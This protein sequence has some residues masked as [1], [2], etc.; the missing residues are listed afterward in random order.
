MSKKHR[1]KIDFE[2]TLINNAT[3]P[4]QWSFHNETFVDELQGQDLNAAH[5]ILHY[6]PFSAISRIFHFTAIGRIFSQKSHIY[7]KICSVSLSKIS[8]SQIFSNLLPSFLATD[9]S[10]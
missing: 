7:T 4:L 6:L 10:P 2:V 1:K 9:S 3:Q 8:Q 5:A